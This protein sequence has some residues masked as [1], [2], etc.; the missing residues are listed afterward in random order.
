M[1]LQRRLFRVGIPD[2]GRGAA[3]RIIHIHRSL[4]CV[5]LAAYE[6]QQSLL[7]RSLGLAGAV[8]IAYFDYLSQLLL[9]ESSTAFLRL[10]AVEVAVRVA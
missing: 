6:R 4:D 8:W 5:P 7:R 10:R 3:E 9:I 1:E 2:P